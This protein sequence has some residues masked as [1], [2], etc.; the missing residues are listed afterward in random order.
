MVAQDHDIAAWLAA[1]YDTAGWDERTERDAVERLRSRGADGMTAVAHAYWAHPTDHSLRW[2]MVRCASDVGGGDAEAFLA[3]VL[4]AEI[5][6]ETSHDIHNF[7][8]VA[9]ESSQRMQA[10]RG[11]AAAAAAGSERA[12]AALAIT[13]D[14]PVAAVRYVASVVVRDLP[15]EVRASE[16]LAAGQ[17]RTEE[18]FRDTR[19]ADVADLRFPE[20]RFERERQPAPPAADGRTAERPSTRR[21]PHIR[22]QEGGSGG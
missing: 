17:R 3:D 22:G 10:V 4:A 21:A 5:G 18:E 14:H 20:E 1:A 13:L 7:S 8:S 6:P 12:V 9:E 19:V 11:L 16:A 15:A 2:A